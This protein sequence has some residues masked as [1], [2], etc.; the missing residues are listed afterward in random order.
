LLILFKDWQNAFRMLPEENDFAAGGD[1]AIGF[2]LGSGGGSL[3]PTGWEWRPTD[4]QEAEISLPELGQFLAE[5]GARDKFLA[6]KHH[7]TTAGGAPHKRGFTSFRYRP[8][9]KSSKFIIKT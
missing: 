9:C 4:P 8:E 5:F 3:Q 7:V 2:R 6:A 1:L